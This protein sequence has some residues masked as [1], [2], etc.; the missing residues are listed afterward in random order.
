[1]K[2]IFV[3]GT[4]MY[5]FRN[6]DPHFLNSV[7]KVTKATT[8]GKLFHLKEH[9]CPGL[10][11][12]ED[13]IHG[14]L[15]YFNDNDDKIINEIDNFESYFRNDD[16]IAYERKNITCVDNQGTEYQTSSY[17]FTHPS[18]K[19]PTKLVYLPTGS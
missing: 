14:E 11:P 10:I 15:I 6:H 17:I 5:G 2:K 9:D 16:Q 1:M 4:L 13:I 3:Y 12:G 7:V 19:D 8:K 18:L